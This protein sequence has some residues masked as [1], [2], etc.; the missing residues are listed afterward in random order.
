MSDSSDGGGH[1][2]FEED[3]EEKKEDLTNYPSKSISPFKKKS[4]GSGDENDDDYEEEFNIYD[5]DEEDEIDV[6]APPIANKVRDSTKLF[7]DFT[8]KSKFTQER[9]SNGDKPRDSETKN[10]MSTTGEE[11]A[12]PELGNN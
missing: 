12:D 6:E 2:Y 1:G 5:S 4:S 10:P 8:L 9:L 11:K 3:E 7:K